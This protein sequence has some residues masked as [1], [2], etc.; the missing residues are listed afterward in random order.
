MYEGLTKE[1][2]EKSLFDGLDLSVVSG[3]IT[4]SRFETDKFFVTK[5]FYL[6]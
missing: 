1:I 4:N 2:I 3:K 5:A 6:W